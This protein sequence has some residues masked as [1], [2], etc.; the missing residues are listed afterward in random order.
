[1]TTEEIKELVIQ[2]YPNSIYNSFHFEDSFYK[3]S[4]FHLKANLL[5][6]FQFV[7]KEGTGFEEIIELQIQ[8][9]HLF[10]YRKLLIYKGMPIERIN[11]KLLFLAMLRDIECFN[12][13]AQ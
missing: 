11:F 8:L 12:C 6:L 2:V 10:P 4:L 5:L 3:C 7:Y 1:M 13:V 9:I